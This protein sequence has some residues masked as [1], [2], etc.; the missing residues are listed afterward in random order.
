MQEGRK[1]NITKALQTLTQL[2]PATIEAFA[3]VAI[4]HEEVP[5]GIEPMHACRVTGY[6]LEQ[7][8]LLRTLTRGINAVM[9]GIRSEDI[10]EQE[11]GNE[12]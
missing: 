6:P 11:D 5:E 3:I 12:S 8:V 2:D 4:Y 7:D 9:D 1:M 10:E